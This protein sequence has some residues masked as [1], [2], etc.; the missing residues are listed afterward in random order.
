M[1]FTDFLRATVLMSAVAASVLAALAVVGAGRDQNDL[2]IPFTA[3]WWVVAAGIGVALG[4]GG[5]ISPQITRLLAMARTSASLPEVR[6]G[7]MLVNRLWPLGVV[8]IAAGAMAFLAP[9]VP[10]IGAGFALIWA[11][12]WRRQERAVAAIEE[13]DGVRFY[14][15]RTS[16]VKA[17]ALVRT[18][19]F[20]TNLMEMNGARDGDARR[21]PGTVAASPPPD[22]P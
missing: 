15:E 6:P 19:W 9:Q 10:A 11:L 5:E 21:A 17:I 22:S 12:A 4:R 18:P 1:R 7:R 8:T 13:R 3:G 20:K 2:V 16:P 14:V